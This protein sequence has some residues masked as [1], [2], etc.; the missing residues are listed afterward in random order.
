MKR[1]AFE[2]TP[3]TLELGELQLGRTYRCALRVRN[4]GDTD[5]RARVWLEP[6]HA[7]RNRVRISE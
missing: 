7:N 2:V 3:P 5:I 4:A 1:E 6:P